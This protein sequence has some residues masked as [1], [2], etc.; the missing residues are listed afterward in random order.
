MNHG[1][2][3]AIRDIVVQ[4]L[5]ESVRTELEPLRESIKA[6]EDRIGKL[7]ANQGKAIVGFGALMV[8][9]TTLWNWISGK[10]FG[11]HK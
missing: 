10:I 4:P 3:E 5:V 2:L 9:V 8:L 7:E 1:E 6:H 11:E